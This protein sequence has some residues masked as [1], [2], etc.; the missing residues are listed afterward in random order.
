MEEIFSNSALL[1]VHDLWFLT[2]VLVRSHEAKPLLFFSC[3]V[4][5]ELMWKCGRR[6]VLLVLTSVAVELISLKLDLS[7]MNVKLGC[8]WSNGLQVRSH[9][10][11]I[12]YSYNYKKLVMIFISEQSE[13]LISM[14]W[15]NNEVLNWIQIMK[16]WNDLLHN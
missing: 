9:S 8:L 5:G 2:V 11:T 15:K 14:C 7:R 1:L 3:S 10:P 4:R 16:I 6:A 12:L 13:V